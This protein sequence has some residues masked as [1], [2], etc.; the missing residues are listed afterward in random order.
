MLQLSACLEILQAVI[1]WEVSKRVWASHY[2]NVVDAWQLV[3]TCVKRYA[4]K[5]EYI[6]GRI[7]SNMHA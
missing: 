2:E 4:N 3:M 6:F 7:N 1:S 5:V